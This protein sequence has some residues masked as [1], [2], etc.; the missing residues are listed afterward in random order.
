MDLKLKLHNF[1]YIANIF[2]QKKKLICNLLKV[3]VILQ[4]KRQQEVQPQ[5]F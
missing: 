4:N 1:F 5:A 3:I 2:L